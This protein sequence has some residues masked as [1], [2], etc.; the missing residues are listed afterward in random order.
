M[1]QKDIYIAKIDAALNDYDDTVA[2]TLVKEV[3]S[4]F[5]GEDEQIKFG[6]D[7]FRGRVSAPGM[8]ISYDNQGDLKKLR[9]KLVSLKE[10]EHRALEADLTRLPLLAVDEDIAECERLLCSGM[11]DEA[12]RFV[13][14]TVQVYGAEIENIAVGLTGYGYAAEDGTVEGDLTYIL[15]H[16]KHYR[17]NLALDLAKSASSPINVSASAVSQNSMKVSLTVT[18]VAEQVQ[19]LPEAVLNDEQKNQIK[20]LLLDLD[21]AKGK[22]KEEAEKPLKKVLSW[23]ADKGI[24]VGIAVLPYVAQTLAGL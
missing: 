22:S 20:A 9:G 24:D 3:V 11:E 16:L 1:S 10:A 19:S 8:S 18:Q 13:D 6:L 21:M 7:R 15:S 23:L 17:A 2:G 14:R 5:A 4:V 12:R